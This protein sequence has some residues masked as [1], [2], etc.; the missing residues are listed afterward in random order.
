MS[1][2]SKALAGGWSKSQATPNRP[3]G[4]G[5]IGVEISQMRD[6]DAVSDPC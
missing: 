3:V 1:S 5:Y 6:V 4:D 2:R